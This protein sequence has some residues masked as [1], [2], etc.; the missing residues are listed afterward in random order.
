ME[1]GEMTVL[2]ANPFGANDLGSGDNTKP[3]HFY[4]SDAEVVRLKAL[5]PNVSNVKK[6]VEGRIYLRGNRNGLFPPDR[7]LGFTLEESTIEPGECLVFSPKITTPV[8]SSQGI[9]IQNYN[10][11]DISRNT[12]SARE[13]QGEGHFIHDYASDYLK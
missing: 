2:M 4:F 11:N 3:V 8:E 12:L 9:S 6:W 13:P 5:F 7:F 1:V 10:V